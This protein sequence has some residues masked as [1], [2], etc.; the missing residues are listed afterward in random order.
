MLK[1]QKSGAVLCRSCGKLVGVHDEKCL[2]CGHANPALW[3][4]APALRRLGQDL[5]FVP[6]VIGGCAAL[7]TATLLVDPDG[8]RTTGLFS[9]LSP[10]MRALFMFGASGA[11]PVFVYDRWWTVLSAAWLHGGVLH[12]IF[13]MMWIRQLAPATAELYGPGRMMIIYTAAA[14]SGFGLSTLAGAFFGS[15]PF[16]F[17]QGAQFTIGASAPLFGLLGAL[18]LYGRRSGSSYIR[19]QAFGNAAILFIFG[20][21][22]QGVDNY[23][24]LG[25]F[26]GGYLTA[27]W[28][29]P[30]RP[31]RVEDQIAGLACLGLSA[32][33]IL[34][35]LFHGFNLFR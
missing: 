14:I 24:H 1:R 13:N 30:L 2:N 35:S 33:S 17:L 32:A 15:L 7:Y 12:I 26:A 16:A 29:D 20:L 3:G 21:V 28:L 6:V 34:A 23:A 9:F 10:S 8:I 27:R 4:F 22:M 5:G 11:V 31:E 18:V 25:G 19:G